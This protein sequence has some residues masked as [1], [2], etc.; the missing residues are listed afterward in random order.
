MTG[1]QG[2]I[3]HEAHAPAAAARHLS[4][5]QTLKARRVL[6]EAIMLRGTPLNAEMAKSGDV[7][8]AHSFP[9][10]AAMGETQLS[11]RISRTEFVSRLWRSRSA[12]TLTDGIANA[13][14]SRCANNAPARKITHPP[15]PGNSQLAPG[16]AGSQDSLLGANRDLRLL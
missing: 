8:K 4:V 11:A 13:E 14:L 5:A 10:S 7:R 2:P 12:P 3:H 9:G 6:A 1:A 16:G 15:L